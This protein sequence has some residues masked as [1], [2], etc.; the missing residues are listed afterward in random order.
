MKHPQN[1]YALFENG[2]AIAITNTRELDN[3]NRKYIEINNQQ[4]ERALLWRVPII[5]GQMLE[6]EILEAA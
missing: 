3:E 2:E 5:K 6:K 1:A 4:I